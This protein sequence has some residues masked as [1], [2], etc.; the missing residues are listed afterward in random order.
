AEDAGVEVVFGLRAPVVVV[1][2]TMVG[3]TIRAID[4][5]T[6]NQRGAVSGRP[7]RAFGID[8]D[9]PSIGVRSTTSCRNPVKFFNA[10]S[11]MAVP[12]SS[13]DVVASPRAPL[14]VYSSKR[15]GTVTLYFC[16][17]WRKP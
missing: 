12:Y 1:R 2:T 14:R 11:I 9:Y 10:L 15:H 13:D 16:M 17:V 5:D 7:E 6:D 8:H 4:I 3:L